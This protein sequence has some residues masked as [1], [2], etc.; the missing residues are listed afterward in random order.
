MSENRIARST[1]RE[2]M[3]LYD[4]LWVRISEQEPRAQWGPGFIGAFSKNLK[5]SSSDVGCFSAKNLRYFYCKSLIWQQT[6][7]K[8]V[9]ETLCS[10]GLGHE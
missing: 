3:V 1:N 5:A 2:L 8:L 6:V 7:A 4:E 9:S 10:K